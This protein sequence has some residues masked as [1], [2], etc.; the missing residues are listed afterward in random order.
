MGCAGSKDKKSGSEQKR[1]PQK[2]KKSKS[3]H[4]KMS[5]GSDGRQEYD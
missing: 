5:D 3:G 1:P 2:T 4:D